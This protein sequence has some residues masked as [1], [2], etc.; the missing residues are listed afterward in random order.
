MST[1]GIV[2]KAEDITILPGAWVTVAY[3]DDDDNDTV[4]EE[5]AY[6]CAIRQPAG[7]SSTI[8]QKRICICWGV[9][10]PGEKSKIT[11]FVLSRLFQVI[12]PKSIT[13]ILP[14]PVNGTVSRGRIEKGK[15]VMLD[16]GKL[17]TDRNFV[18]CFSCT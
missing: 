9:K 14:L 18:V 12:E 2:D 10:E 1:N 16:S 11:S 15:R 4:Y 6:V 8:E 7:I 3:S 5:Y 17:L 13:A